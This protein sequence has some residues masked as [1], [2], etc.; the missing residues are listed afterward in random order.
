MY[1]CT[2]APVTGTVY[3][4]CIAEKLGREKVWQIDSFRAFGKRTFGE[5]IDR[6]IVS[7]NLDGFSLVNHGQ[8]AKF[9]KLSPYQTFPL[10]SIWLAILLNA[11]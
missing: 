6:P 5:L 10:Y 1:V 11:T 9:A 4:Y 7:T 8:F 3:V 2:F